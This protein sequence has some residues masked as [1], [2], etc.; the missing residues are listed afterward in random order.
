[1]DFLISA[2]I[3]TSMLDQVSFGKGLLIYLIQLVIGIVIA[4]V[5]VGVLLLVG[6]GGG[7]MH[8]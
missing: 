6:V 2:A 1:M 5:I 4:I 7:L 8:R 3:Y